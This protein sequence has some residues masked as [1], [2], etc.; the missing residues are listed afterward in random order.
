[1]AIAVYTSIALLSYDYRSFG[2][3]HPQVVITFRAEENNMH[4]HNSGDP[5]FYQSGRTTALDVTL[6]KG[7]PMYGNIS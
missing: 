6:I 2:Y 3:D 4:I 7:M 5:T 1:M